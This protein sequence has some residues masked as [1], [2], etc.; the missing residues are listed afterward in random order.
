[1]SRIQSFNNYTAINGAGSYQVKTVNAT[2]SQLTSIPATTNAVT[3]TV[4]ANASTRR[5]HLHDVEY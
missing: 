5:C 4:T 1:M 3:F 2:P